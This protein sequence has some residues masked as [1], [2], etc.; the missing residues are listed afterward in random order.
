M[1]GLL[2]TLEGPDGAGKTSQIHNLANYFKEQDYPVVTTREPGGTFLGSAI[3]KLLLNPEHGQMTEK[4]EVLLYAADRAQHVQEIILPALARGEVVICDRYIDSTLAYQGY[5][6]KLD[7]DFLESVNS[8]ATGGLIPDLTLILDV[9]AQV[10]L[11]RII[12]GREQGAGIDRIE[13]QALEFHQS[14]RAGYLAIAA[15]Q[16]NRCRVI[17][18][19]QSI[20]L[21][22]QEVVGAVQK[23]LSKS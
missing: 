23:Y 14:V 16:P 20:E 4:A 17:D 19:T 2:I 12:T 21:V 6:R 7:I 1:K 15:Q 9:P 3:R 18:A 11:A 8:I 13:G 5:G 10:G 22:G